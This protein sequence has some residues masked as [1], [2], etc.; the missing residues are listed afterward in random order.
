M[1]WPGTPASSRREP[2]PKPSVGRALFEK[3]KDKKFWRPRGFPGVYL[4]TLR[5]LLTE[6]YRV[7]YGPVTSLPAVV[8][9]LELVSANLL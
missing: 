6:I 3:R 7:L 8:F 1:V 4:E 2:G 9:N 5:G